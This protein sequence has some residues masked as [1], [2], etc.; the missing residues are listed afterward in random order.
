MVHFVL[1]VAAYFFMEFVAWSSHKYV[2]H[3]FLWN[4]H[5]DHHRKDHQKTLPL[6]TEDKRFEKNDLFFLI[7]ASPAIILLIIGLT[8]NLYYLVSIG[9][10]ITLYGFTY[11]TIHDIVIHHRVKAPFLFNVKNS[12]IRSIINA[13]TAHHWPK[14]KDDFHNYGLLI[15]PSRFFTK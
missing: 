6:Q 10:G 7:Y 3:G 1:I 4:W 12:Y 8:F 14:T 13:H 5:K 15:F 2:M 9:V 11:F